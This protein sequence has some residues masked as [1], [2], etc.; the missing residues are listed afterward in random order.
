MASLL[1]AR[2]CRTQMLKQLPKQ[3]MFR[4]YASEGR[5]ALTR[6]AKRQTL[7]ERA[8]APAGDTG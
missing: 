5:D 2:L 1:A 6:A 8:M 3:P 4:S 7:R